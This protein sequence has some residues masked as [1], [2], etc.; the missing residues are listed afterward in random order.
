MTMI[1]AQFSEVI[2]LRKDIKKKINQDFTNVC[3]WFIDNRLGTHFGDD[4]T[5]SIFSA[6]KPNIKK[7]PKLD[8]IYNKSC[9]FFK[10]WLAKLMED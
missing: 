3:N 10:S 9:K 8:I 4:K 2:M 7:V 5:K 6:T 1:H